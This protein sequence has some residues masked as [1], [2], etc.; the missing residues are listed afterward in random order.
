MYDWKIF[1]AGGFRKVALDSMLNLV[2]TQCCFVVTS[3]R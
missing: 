1:S 3:P 2:T